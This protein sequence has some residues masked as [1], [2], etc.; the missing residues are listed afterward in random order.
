[1]IRSS[2]K[3]AHANSD[4]LLIDGLSLYFAAKNTDEIAVRQLISEFETSYP[5]GYGKQVVM[6]VIALLPEEILEWLKS[7]Y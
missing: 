1:M 7:L 2:R 3:F 5:K 4:L 6:K